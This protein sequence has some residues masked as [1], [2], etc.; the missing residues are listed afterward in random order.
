V[1]PHEV[2]H[3]VLA[4]QFGGKQIPRWADEGMAVLDEPRDRIDRHLR[5]L[6]RQRDNGQLYTSRELIGLKDYPEPR[7][8]A[9]F[10]AQSV[11]LTE[12][13]AKAKGPRELARFIRDGQ[14]DGYETALQSHYGWSFDDLE[15]E[16]R[17][18][19]FSE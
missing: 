6:P 8:I 16:W 2:T 17:K 12:F 9:A 13:L 15:R 10:Y 7:R 3:T 18:H 11:S 14:R 4:G 19:A 5:T 1:L